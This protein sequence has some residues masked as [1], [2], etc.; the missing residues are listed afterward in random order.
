MYKLSYKGESMS[1]GHF[2]YQ[3][4]HMNYVID[5]LIK[6]IKT[7]GQIDKWGDKHGFENPKAKLYAKQ[8]V[9]RLK[10]LEKALH[11]YDWYKSDDTDEE[12]FIQEYENIYA[13]QIKDISQE[14]DSPTLLAPC[15]IC[16]GIVDLL[17]VGEDYFVS[18]DTCHLEYAGD[19]T[20][21]GVIA[22]WN[23]RVNNTNHKGE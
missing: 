10:K 21:S 3:D 1:G 9:R 4:Q 11:S 15:P 5:I 14:E 20:E 16:G 22:G 18:C 7:D 23:K 13:K 19:E 17:N 6:D 8:M 2:D 12:F